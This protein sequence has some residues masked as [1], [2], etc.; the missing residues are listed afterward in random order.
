LRRLT[1]FICVVLFVIAIPGISLSDTIDV[2]IKGVDDGVKTNKQQ[3]YKEAVMNAKLQAIERAGVE[4]E[5][6]TKVVNFQMRFK[7]VE[8]KAT[9]VLLP[10]FQIM[11]VGYLTDG[12]YQIVLSGRIK[13]G[14]GEPKIGPKSLMNMGKREK[15]KGDKYLGKGEYKKAYESFNKAISHFKDILNTFPGSD[16]ALKIE[17]EVIIEAIESIKNNKVSPIIAD[18]TGY[19]RRFKE[20]NNGVVEDTKTGLEWIPKT[21]TRIT[22]YQ[23]KEW[24]KS[25]TINGGGWRLPT[26]DELE[27]LYMGELKALYQRGIRTGNINTYRLKHE[28]GKREYVVSVKAVWTG[29]VKGYYDSGEPHIV[30]CLSFSSGKR[31]GRYIHFRDDVKLWAFAVRSRR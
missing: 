14:K 30:W 6:I 11:D 9:A 19:Y 31:T 29:K 15:L 8:S 25:I 16:E 3:D 5:S 22:W 2:L 7:A 1:I 17:K 26:T 18:I 21:D 4:I 10:G 20:F 28:S 23:A 12:T 13:T 27:M 24:V